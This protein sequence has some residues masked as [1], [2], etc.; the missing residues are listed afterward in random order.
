MF[1]ASWTQILSNGTKI[2]AITTKLSTWR[3]II[4]AGV[5]IVCLGGIGTIASFFVQGGLSFDFLFPGEPNIEESNTE[6]STIEESQPVKKPKRPRHHH[7]TKRHY[8][9]QP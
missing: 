3:W 7:A 5:V 2:K 9:T 6:E 4:L 1:R 8:K